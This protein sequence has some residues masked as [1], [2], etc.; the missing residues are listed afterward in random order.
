MT[1]L[2]QFRLHKLE[3]S[4]AR[5]KWTSVGCDCYHNQSQDPFNQWRRQP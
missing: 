1:Q 3:G 4:R 2:L 5:V